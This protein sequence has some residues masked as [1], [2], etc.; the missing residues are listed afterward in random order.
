MLKVLKDID[1]AMRRKGRFLHSAD[2]CAKTGIL[3]PFCILFTIKQL[4]F[5]SF[6][7]D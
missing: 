7:G 6:F 3:V 4:R 5:C 2:L 1:K